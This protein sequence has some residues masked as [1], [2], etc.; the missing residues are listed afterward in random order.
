MPSSPVLPVALAL[1]LVGCGADAPPQPLS[2]H[3]S[4]FWDMM[5]TLAD[6][7]GAAAPAGI[8]GISLLPTLVGR[9]EQAEHESLYWEYHGL[10]DGAQAVRMGRW[11][12][13]R[14]GVHSDPDAPVE[15][16]DLVADAGETRDV[17]A[18]HPDV[19][20][21]IVGVMQSRTGARLPEWNFAR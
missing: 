18:D 17:S 10:W 12:G 13:V 19:V 20:A 4:A 1:V 21:R 3:V 2:D 6:V 16:Y 8:D 9:V 11:K 15:L 5:P 14:L 7:T